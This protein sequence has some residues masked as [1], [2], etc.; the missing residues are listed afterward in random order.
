MK[1]TRACAAPPLPFMLVFALAGL[2]VGGA[3]AA[4]TF[5]GIA[6][7]TVIA[8]DGAISSEH[9]GQ[10]THVDCGAH[11]RKMIL[12]INVLENNSEVWSDDHIGDRPELSAVIDYSVGFT[13][14]EGAWTNGT[15]FGTTY[16]GFKFW[17]DSDVDGPTV[18]E[19]GST[20][21]GGGGGGG[22]GAG[23]LV[24][25][26][27]TTTF[28]LETAEIASPR[29]KAAIVPRPGV[30]LS[31]VLERPEGTFLGEEWAVLSSDTGEFRVEFAS[32]DRFLDHVEAAIDRYRPA[33]PRSSTVL[34]VESVAHPKNKRFMPT[35]DV[36]P[37]DREVDWPSRD[38]AHDFW[39]RAEMDDSG[40]LDRLILLDS[41]DLRG[42]SAVREALEE[43]LALEHADERRHRTIVFGRA[44]VSDA[45]VLNVS[46]SLVLVPPCCCGINESF[47][48]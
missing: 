17:I 40:E 3:A 30:G 35:P 6:Q 39:F 1:K 37:V 47:C 36:V 29:A 38:G 28:T 43:R 46:Q 7:A 23:C 24:A 18:P 15:Q 42:N 19:C 22:G 16:S 21:G 44:A 34:V 2:V 27:G 11:S 26:G 32:S 14:C 20:G 9:S 45:G 4:C 25:S 5:N 13:T 48:V 8:Y 41:S 10:I 12:R 31:R 33:D